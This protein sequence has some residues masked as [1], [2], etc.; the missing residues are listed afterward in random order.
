MEAEPCR[1][2]V[3]RFQKLTGLRNYQIAM[4]CGCTQ[5]AVEKW[6]QGISTPNGRHVLRM[7][8]ALLER[9][10]D[11]TKATHTQ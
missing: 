7:V 6:R 1:E 8:N 10:L 11:K 9:N 2:F 3:I 4:L 5:S